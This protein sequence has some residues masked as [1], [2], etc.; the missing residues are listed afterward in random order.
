MPFV[1]VL[2]L[3]SRRM[4]QHSSL[5]GTMAGMSQKWDGKK[6]GETNTL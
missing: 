6:A 5:R 3:E 4:S 2:P 1:M